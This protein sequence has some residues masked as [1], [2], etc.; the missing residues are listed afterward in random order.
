MPL[1]TRRAWQDYGASIW[2]PTAAGGSIPFAPD[3][4]IG[5]LKAMRDRY[6]DHLY[7]RYGFLDAF[8]PTLDVAMTTRRGGVVPGVGWFDNDYLGIDQGPIVLMIENYRTG[9]IWETM[10]KNPHMVRGLC[11]LGFRGVWLEGRCP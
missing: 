6:G 9:L 7:Q 8:N 1:P 2:G 5:A 3:I 11:R 10:K 4:T